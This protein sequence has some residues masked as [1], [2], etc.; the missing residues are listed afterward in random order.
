MA[1]DYCG[2]GQM[3]IAAVKEPVPGV[4]YCLFGNCPPEHLAINGGA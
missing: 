4:Q 3:R 2:C 1:N